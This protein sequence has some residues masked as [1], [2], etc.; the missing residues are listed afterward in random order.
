MKAATTLPKYDE[1]VSATGKKY[2][3]GHKARKARRD[4]VAKEVGN[5]GVLGAVKSKRSNY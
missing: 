5:M 4:K 3:E 2:R 1:K